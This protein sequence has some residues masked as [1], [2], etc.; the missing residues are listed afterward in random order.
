MKVCKMCEIEKDESEFEKKR[1]EC[2]ECRHE[3]KRMQT[4]FAEGVAFTKTNYND[5]IRGRRY[6]LSI[7]DVRELKKIKNCECCGDDL[8]S[9]NARIDHCHDTGVVRGVICNS[10]NTIEGMSKNNRNRLLAV[11]KYAEERCD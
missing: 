9:D 2:R 4:C 11:L 6:G 10:C 5:I 1:G 3:K 8:S 7:Y